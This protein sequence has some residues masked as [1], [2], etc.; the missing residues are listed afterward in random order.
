MPKNIIYLDY[1]ATAPVA[2]GVCDAMTDAVSLGG[3]A[4]SVHFRGRAARRLVEE[5]R[6]KLAACLGSRP[7]NIVYTSGGTEANRIALTA[8]G[9]PRILASAIEHPAVA[10][11]C[12]PPHMLPVDT[13]GRL[14]LDA[15]RIALA[16]GGDRTIV[17]L[18][19][20][21]NETG[22][23]QPVAEAAAIVHAAGALLH[24]DAVQGLGKLPV[25][26]AALGVDLLSVS[27]HKIGGPAGVGAL[28]LANGV[29]LA[30]TRA[31][32]GQEQGRRPGTENLAGIA[33][34]G[35]AL[36]HLPAALA[37][38]ERQEALRLR[39]E[40]ALAADA[41]IFGQGA[42]RLANTVCLAMPG[43][44]AETQVMAFDLAGFC[45]S[46]GAACSSGKVQASPVLLAMGVAPDLAA[47]A[48]RVSFGVETTADEIDAFAAQWKVLYQRK[49]AA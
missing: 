34:F 2:Q 19:L 16:E 17:S 39:L 8:S 5:A 43:V 12:E 22:V 37:D 40:A 48:I 29:V 15:L 9:R 23:V 35:A 49:R 46:A 13:Q 31:A 32:G 27:A 1:N 7:A 14:N 20:A 11:Y 44:A 4:S 45:V 10:A 36:D 25:D 38:R 18:M 41:V 33:G 28:V 30:G 47:A 6:T 42:A 21:N 3:N 24:C 26:M